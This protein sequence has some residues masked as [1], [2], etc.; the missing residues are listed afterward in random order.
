MDEC[1]ES[2]RKSHKI[3]LHLKKMFYGKKT[4]IKR[5]IVLH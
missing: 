3:T 4:L 5:I 1:L 2:F